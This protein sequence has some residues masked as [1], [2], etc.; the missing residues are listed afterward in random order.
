MIKYY[1]ILILLFVELTTIY[2]QNLSV[3]FTKTERECVLGEASITIISGALP[4]QYLW[5]NGAITS[6]VAQ[7]E[8]GE[9]SV[10]VTDAQNNDTIINFDIEKQ[11]CKPIAENHFT[12]NYDGYNDTWSISRLENFPEFDLF[13]YNRWGQQVHHQMNQYIP[14]DGR[15]LTLPLPD[16]TYYYILYFSKTDKNKFIKGD[17][18]I[19]R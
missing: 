18:S 11:I 13:V 2:A 5:N 9:Y 3:S 10:K 14:W 6:S 1:C 16:A 4:I 19:I 15:S 17:V 8:E 7:L 12:P